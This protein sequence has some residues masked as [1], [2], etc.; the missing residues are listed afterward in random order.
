MNVFEKL[1]NL[2]LNFAN[3]SSAINCVCAYSSINK[4]VFP[5]LLAADIIMIPFVW[6]INDGSHGPK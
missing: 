4:N 5:F 1:L 3:L 6:L 2:F